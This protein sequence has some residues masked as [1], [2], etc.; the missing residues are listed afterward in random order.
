MIK[1][2]YFQ[3]YLTGSVLNSASYW[4]WTQQ[5][6]T[7]SGSSEYENR[8]FPTAS[9][10]KI[11]VIYIPPNCA[12]EQIS[13]L[14]F[15][16]KPIG[17]NTYDIWDDGNGNLIDK[18]NNDLHVGNI[19]YSNGVIIITAED[20]APAFV[21]NNTPPDPYYTPVGPNGTGYTD[22]TLTDIYVE[23]TP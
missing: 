3:N 1:Q 9:D 18:N 16:L 19:I 6:T 20:Y 21:I 23:F 22:T 13:R 2:L 7:F 8:S 11:A 4:D 15:N 5:S 12:G 14:T 17:A 10:A